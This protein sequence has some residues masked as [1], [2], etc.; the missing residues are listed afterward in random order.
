MT[1][2]QKKQRA[3]NLE[4]ARILGLKDYTQYSD[5]YL[6]RLIEQRKQDVLNALG[7]DLS[8]GLDHITQEDKPINNIN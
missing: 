8:N 2:K 6:R 3:H 7:I 4:M 1:P 5:T